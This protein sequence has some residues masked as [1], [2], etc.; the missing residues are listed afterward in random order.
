MAGTT[1]Y[2][3]MGMGS[4]LLAL[5]WHY[6]LASTLTMVVVAS[7]LVSSCLV[8]YAAGLYTM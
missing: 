4:R 7:L 8:V 1:Y 2:V 6:P 5:A 3:T